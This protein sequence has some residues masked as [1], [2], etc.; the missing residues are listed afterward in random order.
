M[1]TTLS[2]STPP[3]ADAPATYD[4]FDLILLNGRWTHGRSGQSMDDVDPYTND[5]LL[6]IPLADQADLDDAFAAAAAAQQAWSRARPATRAAVLQW[7]TRSWH[8]VGRQAAPPDAASLKI[9]HVLHQEDDGRV[10]A[11]RAS[12]ESD[13]EASPAVRLDTDCERRA[14]LHDAE[15]ESEREGG[16]VPSVQ[17]ILLELPEGLRSARPLLLNTA[18]R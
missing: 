1:P 15:V 10:G 13:A 7:R 4:S 18:P 2:T 12:T 16:A 8:R 17:G 6:R 5:V 9:P 11:P 14:H 3:P